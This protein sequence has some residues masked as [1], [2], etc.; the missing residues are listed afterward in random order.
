MMN[1][2]IYGLIF[3]GSALMICNIYGYIRYA[4]DIQRKKDWGR[5]RTVL[6]LPILLLVMF[7]LGYM[8]VGIFGK[9]DIIVSG[10]L[11]GGS[12]YVFIMYHFLKRVTNRIQKN[13]KTEAR[14]MAS[15]ATNRAKTSF[16]SSMSHE[17]RTPMNA[18]IGLDTIVLQDQSL[19]PETRNR[20]EKIGVSARHL[21]SL[22]NDVLDMSQ[23]ESDQM[24]IRQ[25]PFSLTETLDLLDLL[26]Q[27][28]CDENGLEYRHEVFGDIGGTFIGDPLRIKQ[29][30][31]SILRNAVRFTPAPGTVTFTTKQETTPD[32]GCVLHFTVRDIGVG[33]DEVF[34]PKLFDSFSQ[35]DASSTNRF[36]GSGLGLAITKQLLDRMGGTIAV[37]SRKGEGSTFEV[38]IPLERA[39]ESADGEAS[40][41]EE[42]S[43]SLSGRRV[44]IAEDIDLNAEIVSDL[45]ELEGVESE[46]A[47]N[48]QVTVDMFAEHPVGYYDAILM[49]LR[50]PVMDGLHAAR[51]IRSLVRP[52]AKTI[53]IIALTANAL[54]ED[55]RH[56]MEAGMQA[57]ISKPVDADQLYETLGRLLARK[58]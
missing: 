1:Y 34:I 39:E 16:L 22:I 55:V 28:Q 11:F 18:I 48:G 4:R 30:L 38:A 21:L 6:Y 29:V 2:V 49:D 10:I 50:M 7:L 23:I 37:T 20:M 41:A 13:E 14:L 45:L 52:D 54:E 12:V 9:P 57:H 44:L 25:T 51:A 3:L 15:E 19:Q 58:T 27:A 17:M 5:E 53:P 47:E 43:A 8:A 31:L 35:E 32:G 24:V 46:R 40:E 56:S 33:M 36:G 42:W 26:T